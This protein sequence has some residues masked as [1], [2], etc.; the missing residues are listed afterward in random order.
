MPQQF[1][2]IKLPSKKFYFASDS[3]TSIEMCRK[4]LKVASFFGGFIGCDIYNPN[5]TRTN[6]L[7]IILII[8]L[9]FYLSISIYNIY[10]FR[11]DFVRMI[12]CI[13]TLGMGFQG[14]AKL[15]AFIIRRNDVLKLSS[16][17]ESF[18]QNSKNLK[19]KNSFEN[20]ILNFAHVASFLTI[21]FILCGV[22]IIICP[23]IIYLIT[24]K[25]VLHFGFILPWIDPESIHGYILNFLY[26]SLQTYIVIINLICINGFLLWYIFNAFGQYE[27]LIMLLEQLDEFAMKDQRDSQPTKHLIVEIVDRHTALIE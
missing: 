12:F 26:Q 23:G 10:L 4:S 8:D 5:F 22:A 24:N 15:Y 17:A 18:H 9:I 13:A 16:M 11:D 27:C 20:A 19:N 2:S 6:I 7:F 21:I 3:M 14:I 1:C 25:R